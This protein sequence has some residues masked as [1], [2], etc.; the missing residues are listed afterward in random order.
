[1]KINIG[2]N[3]FCLILVLFSMIS[4][5]VY[6]KNN[7]EQNDSS[8]TVKLVV[9][10][11]GISKD[12]ATKFALRSAIEQAF[13]TFV[14]SNTDILN[15]DVVKEEIATV[16]SGNIQSYKELTYTDLDSIKIINIE[17]VVSIGKLVSFAKSKGMSAE[18]A[19]AAFAMDM[20]M[21]E[22]NKNNEMKVLKNLYKQLEIIALNGS[23]FDYKLEL[24]NPYQTNDGYY[25]T[26]ATVHLIPNKNMNNF[27]ELYFNT[28][29][30]IKLSDDEIQDLNAVNIKTYGYFSGY[31]YWSG[32]F[33]SEIATKNAYNA[34]IQERR[35]RAQ[36]NSLV[37][38]ENARR[39]AA[40]NSRDKAQSYNRR[41]SQSTKGQVRNGTQS[42]IRITNNREGATISSRN[43]FKD[44]EIDYYMGNDI[45][46]RNE[47]KTLKPKDLLGMF[48]FPFIQSMCGFKIVDNIGTEFRIGY[49]KASFVGGTFTIKANA[50]APDIRQAI[51]LFCYSNNIKHKI[52]TKGFNLE[53]QSNYSLFINSVK[54][55]E[56]DVSLSIKLK[57]LPDDLMKI[58]KLDIIPTNDKIKYFDYK[59]Y[60]EL[61]E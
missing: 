49:T 35:A 37:E 32:D 21:K 10:G 60:V 57:Y 26:V 15:D 30:S 42:N 41:T 59:E 44:G 9:S 13:G 25:E 12:E 58:S 27:W 23:L 61:K 31:Y 43:I 48:Y 34:Y 33:M 11:E 17:A 20:K 6:S 38:L 24:G 39:R 18:L 47:I 8:R 28:I 4:L 2:R 16:S 36:N 54:R 45:M 40:M 52:E 3:P 14:S 56:T 1:M 5:C 46:F 22:L 55:S 50:F 51:R 7:I 29:N 53:E 19:G